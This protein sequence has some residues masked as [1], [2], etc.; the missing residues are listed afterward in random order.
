MNIVMFTL[1]LN[2]KI[3]YDSEKKKVQTSC[4]WKITT[5]Q[6]DAFF[7]RFAYMNFGTLTRPKL[8]GVPGVGSF[9]GHMMHTSRWDYNYTGGSSLGCS[10]TSTT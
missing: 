6:G 7:A 4:G 8:P 2:Q 5:H 10:K 1:I 3:L 9:Q